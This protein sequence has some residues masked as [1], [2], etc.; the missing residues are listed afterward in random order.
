MDCLQPTAA[1]LA[2]LLLIGC[3]VEDPPVDDDDATADD[4]D[5]TADDDDAT[6]DDD[7][8][9]G[10]DDDSGLPVHANLFDAKY[11]HGVDLD[12]MFWDP[13]SYPAWYPAES[14]A[15]GPYVRMA[16]PACDDGTTPA[17]RT[18]PEGEP[19]RC[20]DG[21]RPMLHIRPGTNNK[22]LVHMQGGGTSCEVE[23]DD[24]EVSFL[25]HNC[26]HQ[27]EYGDNTSAFTSVNEPASKNVGGIWRA[28]D[29]TNP[30]ADYNLVAFDKCIGDRNLG[31]TQIAEYDY[32]RKQTDGSLPVTEGTG[33]VYFHGQRMIRATMRMLAADGASNPMDLVVFHA[34]SNGSNGL[35]MYIDRLAAWMEAEV[36]GVA[37]R[38]IASIMVRS[39]VEVE[40]AIATTPL[41]DPSLVYGNLGSHGTLGTHIVTGDTDNADGLWASTRV[42]RDGGLEYE[43]NESWGAID[44]T[45]TIDQSCMDA[46]GADISP[47]LDHMHVLLNHISTPLFLFADLRDNNVRASSQNRFTTIWDEVECHSGDACCH[48]ENYVDAVRPGDCT[49]RPDHPY[50]DAAPAQYSAESFQVRTATTARALWAG[51]ASL[52]E[53][54]PSCTGSPCD[55]SPLP[56]Q[57]WGAFMDDTGAHAPIID[58]DKA[59]LSFI[60]GRKSEDYVFDWVDGRIDTFC[61]DFSGDNDNQ[62]T[63]AAWA[64][65]PAAR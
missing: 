1:A 22:W 63:A 30:F 34:A 7:D 62:G 2:A 37:V 33:P 27:Y 20:T 9:T 56:V 51:H 16:V 49:T 8:A 6:A 54:S 23:S 50:F 61:V 19:I 42:Y 32:R 31:D 4:D 48:D 58:T 29:A 3:P 36:P 25:G 14:G 59:T 52:S 41:P 28:D 44:A 15:P 21:T 39:S 65:C 55:T 46:H 26:W 45:P 12:D 24:S 11:D 60:D 43:R 10:D 47:C 40:A 38:G 64:P 5:A 13:E 35:Y 57:S 18:C 17:S 53:M